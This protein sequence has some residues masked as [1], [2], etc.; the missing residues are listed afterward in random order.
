MP[1]EVGKF[2]DRLNASDFGREAAAQLFTS[3]LSL[4]LALGVLSIKYTLLFDLDPQHRG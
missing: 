4:A 3:T 2:T 1:R